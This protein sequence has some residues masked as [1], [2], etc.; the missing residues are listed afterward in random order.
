MSRTAHQGFTLV[1]VLLAMVIM[2]TMSALTY[3]GIDQLQRQGLR[4]QSIADRYAQLET[5]WLLIED[6]LLHWRN[7]SA[8][9]DYGAEEPALLC[10]PVGAEA[11]ALTRGGRFVLPHQEAQYG[12]TFYT[13]SSLERA[14]YRLEEG[15]LW[16]WHWNTPDRADAPPYQRRILPEVE[17][18]SCRFALE[19]GWQAQWPPTSVGI[20]D[21]PPPPLAIEITLELRDQ[22]SFTRQFLLAAGR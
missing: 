19:D 6:D 22:G 18:L 9:N 12:D 5:A 16:R 13:R 21:T 15:D 1:E 11:L 8:R 2:A 10:D 4:Q 7:R 14:V 20:G 3:Q 17:A